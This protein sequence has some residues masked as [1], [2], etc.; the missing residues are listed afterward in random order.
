MSIFT[1]RDAIG[2]L[3]LLAPA[4]AAAGPA[5]AEEFSKSRVQDAYK[6]ALTRLGYRARVDRDGDIAFTRNGKTY[7]INVS[8]QDPLF[9][10]LFLANVWQAGGG[11]EFCHGL[12]SANQSNS[13]CKGSKAYLIKDRLSVSVEMLLPDLDA[14]AKVMERALDQVD[15]GLSVFEKHLRR[16]M[17]A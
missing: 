6:R 17:G 10:R 7:F 2:R 14:A 9:F 12:E 1:R 11:H 16:L 4:V 15:N 8:E 13:E 5:V 3:G